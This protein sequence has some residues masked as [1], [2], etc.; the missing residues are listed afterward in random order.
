M[1]NIEFETEQ[2]KIKK[3]WYNFIIAQRDVNIAFLSHKLY[4]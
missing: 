1:R 3:I 4:S 2:E